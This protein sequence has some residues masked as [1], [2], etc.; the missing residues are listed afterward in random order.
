M[1]QSIH[2]VLRNALESAVREQIIS[3][4]V[5]R[6]VKVAVPR[7]QVNRGLTTAQPRAVLRAATAHRLGTLYVLALYL[8]LRRGEQLGPRWQDVDLDQAK[9]EVSQ[10]LQRV[11][12]TNTDRKLRNHIQQIQALGFDVTITKAA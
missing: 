11:G 1:I 2:A 4:N 9:L 6:L 12:G 7:Y 5:A 3:R 10:T 8:G